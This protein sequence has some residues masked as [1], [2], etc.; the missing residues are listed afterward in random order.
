MKKRGKTMV[1][2]TKPIT[3]FDS[4]KNFELFQRDNKISTISKWQKLIQTERLKELKNGR[5]NR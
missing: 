3:N 1:V 4:K 5:I 2:G